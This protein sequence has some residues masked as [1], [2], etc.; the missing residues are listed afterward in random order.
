MRIDTRFRETARPVSSGIIC[1]C[2]RFAELVAN[3]VATETI[4]AV[5]AQALGG[6]GARITIESLADTHPI[7]FLAIVTQR[8]ARIVNG[9]VRNVDARTGLPR[10][11][12][13]LARF[14]ASRCATN[15]VDTKTTR[16]L[17]S[18]IAWRPVGLTPST[19]DAHAGTIAITTG[20]LHLGIRAIE[21]RQAST[22]AAAGQCSRTSFAKLIANIAAAKAIDAIAAQTIGGLCAIDAIE[23]LAETRSVTS[24]GIVAGHCARGIDH[25]VGNERARADRSGEIT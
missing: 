24:I 1:R 9:I 20:A 10:E 25:I 7:A 6:L 2:A 12:A 3:V 11:I 4:G 22:I 18:S 13:G 15:A 14:G 16:A 21:N 23:R 19:T 8:G 5:A 17:A